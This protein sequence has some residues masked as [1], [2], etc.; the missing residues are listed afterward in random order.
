MIK[1]SIVLLS[2][3]IPSVAL[4]DNSYM[5]PLSKGVPSPYD[6]LLLTPE[7]VASIIADKETESDRIRVETD[8]VKAEEQAKSQYAISEVQTKS[9]TD[10][11]IIQAQSDVNLRKANQYQE[12]LA[13]EQNKPSPYIWIGLGVVGGTAVTIGTIFLLGKINLVRIP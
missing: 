11:K 2:L 10:K 12:M 6:G 9:E 4:S 8:K 3:T 5:T 7:A 13:K 1:Y